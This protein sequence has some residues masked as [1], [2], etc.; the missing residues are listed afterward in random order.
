MEQTP[1]PQA[2]EKDLQ[3]P[4][5]ERGDAAYQT[6]AN[7]AARRV[8]TV[9]TNLI[10]LRS[11]KSRGVLQG[12]E[13]TAVFMGAASGIAMIAARMDVRAPAGAEVPGE[14]ALLNDIGGQ[15]LNTIEQMRETDPIAKSV[16][17]TREAVDQVP[18]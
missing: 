18:S 4:I 2:T 9:L 12:E 7:E 11:R 5:S 15:F 3:E 10:E 8:W 16:Y 17:A 6:L 14:I 13:V 1:L